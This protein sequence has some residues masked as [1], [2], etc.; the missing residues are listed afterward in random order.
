VVF[1]MLTGK[2]CFDGADTSSTLAEVIKSEPHWSVLPAATPLA[3]R[4][5]LKQCLQKRAAAARSGHR[6]R[7]AVAR[8]RFWIANSAPHRP[9]VACLSSRNWCRSGR[10]VWSCTSRGANWFEELKRLVPTK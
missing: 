5:T 8:R 1:E 7:P 6:G 2:R 10:R 3:V 4:S 9:T